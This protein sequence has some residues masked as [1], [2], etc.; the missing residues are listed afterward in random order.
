MVF[1]LRCFGPL[2]FVTLVV[3]CRGSETTVAPRPDT[4]ERAAPAHDN[5][6]RP[7]V[8]PDLSRLEA[9]VQAQVREQHA[10]LQR[11]QQTP[12]TPPSELS[13]AYGAMGKLLMAAE[14]LDVAEPYFRN[15]RMLEPGDY[16]WP[17]YLAH[18]YKNRGEVPPAMAFF[19]EA[20]ARHPNNAATLV[21]L[22]EMH[23]TAGRPEDA[24]PLFTKALALQPQSL[25]PRF[26]LGRAALA[27]KDFRTAIEHLEAAL[28]L[29]TQAVNI[30]YPLAMAYRGLGDA[31]KAEA[32]LRQQGKFDITPPDP[33]MQE[34]R[35]LLHSAIAYEVE[36][37]RELN[38]GRWEN[39]A[40]RFRKGLELDPSSASLRHRLGTA[41]YMLGRPEEAREAFERVMRESPEYSKAHYSLGVLLESSGRPAEAYERYAAAL[42]HEPGYLE[43][44]VRL[45]GLLRLQGN[46]REALAHYDRV[47]AVNPR[48][49]E[50]LFGSAMV[51]LGLRQ[52]QET[53]D[54]LSTARQAH[55]DDPRFAHALA[56]VL[57]AAPDARVRDG[58]QALAV[59]QELPDEQRRLDMGETMAM[60]LAEVGQYEEAALWQ[61]GAIAAARRAG[62]EGLAQR[63]I[64]SLR[65]YEAGEPCRTPWRDEDLP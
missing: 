5:V 13:G 8:L 44:R 19:E 12:G 6:L 21:W 29:N 42:R 17:Y 14:Y 41:L 43:A 49:A 50:A 36:G 55:A 27:R 22:A 56:R 31:A 64:G 46:L 51:F 38:S 54:R 53:R 59:M 11:L 23:L 1:A 26:G 34:L 15:A 65:L 7:V 47:L 28:A 18:I 20:L 58:R 60:A 48:D 40:A 39:A 30:H 52:Y 2:L 24:E 57:A 62:N 37:I 61:R 25:A 16:R 4:T 63:M 9:S 10:L 33:L 32:H 3:A 45:A 35:E